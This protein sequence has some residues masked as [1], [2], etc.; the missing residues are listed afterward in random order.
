MKKASIELWDSLDTTK[1]SETTKILTFA[2]SH[3]INRHLE[4]TD[5][6]LTNYTKD[7]SKEQ[8]EIKENELAQQR[9]KNLLK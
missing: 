1:F 3:L 2:L 8:K 7:C 6:I 5:Y 9:I 4:L